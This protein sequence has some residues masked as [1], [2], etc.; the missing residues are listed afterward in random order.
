MIPADYHPFNS[1]GFK[2]FVINALEEDIGAGDFSSQACIPASATGKAK[3]LIKQNGVVA[4]IEAAEV[5]LA[6]F[7]ENLSIEKFVS[8]GEKVSANT[9]AAIIRGPV[10]GILATERLILNLMQRLSGIA[11]TTRKLT[12]ML[13]GYHTK[14]LDT[15][16]T[17]P[18]MRHWEKWAVRKGGGM[19]HRIGLYDMVMLK[20]N[21][22]DFAGG[23]APA[24]ERTKK[25]LLDKGLNLAIEV[26]TRNLKEVLQVIEIGGVDRIMLDNF[27][28][29]DLRKALEIIGGHMETEASG[30]IT[31]DNLLQYA[32]TGV[33]FISMGALTH[34]VKS[35]DISLKF[36]D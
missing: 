1:W 2:K 12:G 20:D 17:T 23:I 27:T 14:L 3:L 24:I 6:T 7:A 31:E 30:G 4:G 36:H 32:E 13:E 29:E 11:T 5:I 35:L 21:H 22:I 25:F 28:P 34:S 8:D 33:D 26:E 19:N 15:R 18:G 9:T 10:Q 16:K